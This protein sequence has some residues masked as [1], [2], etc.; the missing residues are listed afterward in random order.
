MR[1]VALLLGIHLLP[2]LDLVSILTHV[3][4]VESDPIMKMPAEIAK[5][6]A[7]ALEVNYP[8]Q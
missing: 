2:G 8:P 7:P 1:D 5:D 4:G 6:G 3:P